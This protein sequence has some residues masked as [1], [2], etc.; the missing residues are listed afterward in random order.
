M[1]KQ[2]KQ[3]DDLDEK[4][5]KLSVLLY[6][7]AII[8]II[9]IAVSSILAY[10]T[11]SEIG[12]KIAAKMSKVIPFPAAIIGWNHVVFL[13]DVQD[14]LMS[15]EKF[16]QSQ[17]FAEEGMRV[18][19][20]T[21]NGKKRLKIKEK[22]IIDKMVED[23][24]I[25]ILAKE[26]GITISDKDVD[27]AV[28]QK[29]N[30]FGTADE[31]KKDLSFSYG[32]SIDDFKQKVVLPSMYSSALAE[33]IVSSDADNSKAKE[34]INQ[35]QKQLEDGKDFSEVVR[36]YS[37]GSSKEKDGQLGW[38]K[39]AQVVPELQAALFESSLKKNSIIESSIGFH[40]VQ[41]DDKKKDAGEDILQL[42]QIF[43]AKN[44][45]ADWLEKQKKQVR[46]SVPL[47]DFI[48]DA[49][50]GVIDFKDENMRNF[51][52]EERSKAQGDASIMF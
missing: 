33:K 8:V 40:I 6:A 42:R 37:E 50:T 19:F 23:K 30:E 24:I 28:T 41:I 1:N 12:S 36:N 31:V 44:T 13:S 52:K 15:V 20:T 34:K 14:N 32:W 4:K 3:V 7:F 9:F 16:Y 17:N 5:I 47:S 39:K 43:V 48:W 27:K 35:A 46:V 26:R 45:F 11:N 10:G 38:V 49:K 2:K 21:Q 22:E 25:E 29:L 51:E 18:D